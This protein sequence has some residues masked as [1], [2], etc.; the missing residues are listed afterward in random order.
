MVALVTCKKEE[1]TE[2]TRVV[3]VFLPLYNRCKY[4]SVGIFID[5]KEQL[6]PLSEV[7]SNRNSN[8]DPEKAKHRH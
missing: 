3:T 8:L 7:Q 4:T 2:G 5:A 6:T 1:E